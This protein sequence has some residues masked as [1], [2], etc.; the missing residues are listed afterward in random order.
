MTCDGGISVTSS[1]TKYPFL[2]R[3]LFIAVTHQNLRND[4]TRLLK[5]L[6]FDPKVYPDQIRLTGISDI[7]K[8]KK[9]IKFIK[10][11]KIGKDSKKLCGYEKNFILEK[12]LESYKKP[13]D[14][15]NFLVE[16][17]G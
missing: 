9:E 17:S 8:F 6:G 14:L 11:S 3:K 4:L 16:K 1:K 7:A 10:Y 13:K 15:I 12:V 2:I 5:N